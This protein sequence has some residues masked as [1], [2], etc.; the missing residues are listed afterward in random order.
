MGNKITDKKILAVL[1]DL[2]FNVVPYNQ[3]F[4]CIS[5]IPKNKKAYNF[6]S[7]IADQIEARLKEHGYDCEF[8]EGAIHGRKV[9]WVIKIT[10][11]G[12]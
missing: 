9:G 3:Q 5:H 6:A 10:K 1:K 11:T 8:D 4:H 7:K 12:D 2:V